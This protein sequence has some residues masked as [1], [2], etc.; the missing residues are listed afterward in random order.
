[1]WL[2]ASPFLVFVLWLW[3]DVFAYYSPVPWKWLDVLIGAAVYALLVVLPL[4]WLA[5]RAVTAVPRLFQHAGWDIQPLEPQFGKF[6]RPGSAFTRALGGIE[7]A[8]ESAAHPREC[9][10]KRS[11]KVQRVKRANDAWRDELRRGCRRQHVDLVEVTTETPFARGLG[12]YLRKRRK[13][14]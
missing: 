13:L 6:H 9:T 4:G 11:Q 7:S 10:Q 12:A 8:I 14:Y 1:M 3:V 2:L 5:H